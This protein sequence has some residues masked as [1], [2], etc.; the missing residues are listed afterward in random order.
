MNYILVFSSCLTEGRSILHYS[1]R[2]LLFR[3]M[4]AVYREIYT[5]HVNTRLGEN[6]E[7]LTFRRLTTPIVVVPH[8]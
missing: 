2:R 5:K 4:M 6:L 3:E 1:D 7:F 8:R